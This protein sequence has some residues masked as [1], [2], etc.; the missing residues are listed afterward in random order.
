MA[1]GSGFVISADGYIVTN[2]H[3]V[4]NADK[5]TV[6]FD[7][8]DEASAKVIGTDEKTDLAVVKIEGKSD[9]PFV[10]LADVEPR[11]GEWVVA[12]GNPFGLGGTVTA[13]I[14]SRAAATSRARPM[15]ISCR[16]TR[17]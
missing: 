17:R 1:A 16:S 12:V 15:A 11:V 2:N 13:G 10:K 9:L 5:V 6:V 8:G 3:V 4:E 14:V 7:N